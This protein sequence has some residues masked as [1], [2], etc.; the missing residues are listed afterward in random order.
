MPRSAGQCTTYEAPPTSGALGAA[1]S[2]P[3]AESNE[4][5]TGTGFDFDSIAP[6]ASVSWSIVTGSFTHCAFVS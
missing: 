2:R 1:S 6:D 3:S 5:V 4:T